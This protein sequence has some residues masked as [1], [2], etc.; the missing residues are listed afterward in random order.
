MPQEQPDNAPTP[1][2]AP[3]SPGNEEIEALLQ[4]AE[5]LV[6]D[7]AG[8]VGL[9]QS[10]A[11]P[12][13]MPEEADPLTAVEMATY[14]VEQLEEA[15]G[16]APPAERV[17]AAPAAMEMPDAVR[18]FAGEDAAGETLSESPEPVDPPA[19]S[20]V[21]AAVGHSRSPGPDKTRHAPAPAESRRAA[22]AI[23]EPETSPTDRQSDTSGE[24]EAEG[25]GAVEESAALSR[26]SYARRIGAALL[27]ICRNI[28]VAIPNSL[29]RMIILLDRPFAGLSPNAKL[30]LGMIALVT[31]VMG[32]LAIALPSLMQDNPYSS[33]AP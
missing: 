14:Q 16:E 19:P 17:D 31:I 25:K 4:Q 10:P 5:S 6:S 1:E 13:P 28:L 11:P 2:D 21:P 9:E 22:T 23:V 3:L 7:I 30:A 18:E 29:I 27:L 20:R 32:G 15:V 8:S 26:R 33:I 24:P 12:T